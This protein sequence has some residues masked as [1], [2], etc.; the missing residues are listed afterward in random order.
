MNKDDW[1]PIAYAIAM[2][3]FLTTID[4]ANANVDE[5]YIDGDKQVIIKYVETKEEVNSKC[6]WYRE[7]YGCTK[8]YPTTNT[9]I[10]Y[11]LPVQCLIEHEKKHVKDMDWHP[12]DWIDES[13]N[14]RVRVYLGNLRH[15]K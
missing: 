9:Y 3:I 12:P 7:L 15:L 14:T 6:G 5:M 11:T 1:V 10:I 13:C 2:F 4:T 8:H